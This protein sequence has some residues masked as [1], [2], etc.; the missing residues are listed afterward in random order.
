MSSPSDDIWEVE[1][2]ADDDYRLGGRSTF[3]SGSVAPTPAPT[4]A[5]ACTDE[6][7]VFALGI[8]WLPF[9]IIILA[10]T[11]RRKRHRG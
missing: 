8:F 10:L 6:R 5:P 11:R 3:G 7:R 1:E 2:P 9:M 4:P